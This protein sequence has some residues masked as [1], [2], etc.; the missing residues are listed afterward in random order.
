MNLPNKLTVARIGMTFILMGFLFQHGV[1]PKALAFVLFL[2]ACLTDFLDGRLARSRGQI[3][4]FG[5]IMDPVADKIL[6][7]GVFLSFVQLQL[8][9]AWM[10]IVIII[11]ELLITGFRL[12]VAR[13]GAV[14]A[15]ERA[16]KHKTVSQMAAIFFILLF[17]VLR[18]SALYFSFWSREF[19]SGFSALVLVSMAIAVILTVTSGFSFFWQN[20]KLIR[21][22]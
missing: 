3:T 7:L 22:L 18:E 13:R 1:L 12:F 14:L 5:K 16:G 11:R 10:V 6:V 19:Q 9:P 4:D 21:S 2:L 15:A 17:L 8:I 20:R